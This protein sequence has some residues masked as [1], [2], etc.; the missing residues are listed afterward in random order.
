MLETYKIEAS[1]EDYIE[2]KKEFGGALQ[3][4]KRHENT[5]FVKL[6]KFEVPDLRAQFPS[7][8][9]TLDS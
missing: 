6:E 2:L 9:V 1:A 4:S 8:T 3:T 5:G 7:L